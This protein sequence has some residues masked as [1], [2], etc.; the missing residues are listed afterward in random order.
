MGPRLSLVSRLSPPLALRLGRWRMPTHHCAIVRRAHHWRTLGRMEP[1]RVSRV[2]C[3]MT[4]RL[5]GR[6]CAVPCS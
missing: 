3:G 4:A 5:D 2:G 1:C 6:V